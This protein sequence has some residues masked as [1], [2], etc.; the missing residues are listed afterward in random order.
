M[1]KEDKH[2]IENELDNILE[3]FDGEEFNIQN[4]VNSSK[5]YHQTFLNNLGLHRKSRECAFPNCSNKSIKRSHSIPKT[6]SLSQI[7]SNGHLLK[8]EYDLKN[9]DV[10]Q[11]KMQQFGLSNASVF[12]GFCAEHENIFKTFEQDGKIDD[13]R[14]AMLQTYRAICRER[15]F[16]EIEIDI[17]EKIKLGYKNKINQEALTIIKKSF[18]KQNKTNEI[19]SVEVSGVDSLLYSLDG[20]ILN[21]TDTN[22]Q[23]LD[24]ENKIFQT[25]STQSKKSELI[26]RIVNIDIQFPISLC[27]FATMKYEEILDVKTAYFLLNI[28]PESNSTTIICVSLDKDKSICDKYCDFALSDPFN[29]LN[30]IESFMI[31]GSDHWFIN[32]DY[33]G[34][35]STAKQEKI[36]H[37]I[38]TTEDSF[39]DEYPISIF[40]NIRSE[41]ISI[42]KENTKHRELTNAENLRIELETKKLARNEYKILHDY[43]K[44]YERLQ[45]KIKH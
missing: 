39:I 22:K 34:K 15:V 4:F 30:M 23:L 29:I 20:I 28:L 44:F 24:F 42:F 16:R 8:P 43:D 36:L 5:M 14:K 40:D 12:P 18:T 3:I 38:L 17:Y 11:M 27:G 35:L 31:N 19:K 37:D 33:W 6:T 7:A 2:I 13:E 21:L 45:N 1:K 41:I 25:L 9:N 32:P 26:N 10:P